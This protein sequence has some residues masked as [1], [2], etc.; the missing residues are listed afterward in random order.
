MNNVS[1]RIRYM[2]RAGIIAAL[3]VAATLL[4]QQISYVFVHA[5]DLGE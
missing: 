1:P 4:L 3:Y 5:D 2:T